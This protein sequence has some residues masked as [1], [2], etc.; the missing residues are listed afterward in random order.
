MKKLLQKIQVLLAM[1][2]IHFLLNHKR[3][4]YLMFETK[5]KNIQ[6]YIVGFVTLEIVYSANCNILN[7]SLE[8]C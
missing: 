1:K 4:G 7:K 8:G 3:N 2:V 6:N 5:L